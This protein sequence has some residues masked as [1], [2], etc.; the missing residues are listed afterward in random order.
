MENISFVSQN[1]LCNLKVEEKNLNKYS[2]F[3]H[4]SHLK[5]SLGEIVE[6]FFFRVAK[7][8]V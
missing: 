1:K 4:M 5:G 3:L 6:I 2:I 7:Q 8:D